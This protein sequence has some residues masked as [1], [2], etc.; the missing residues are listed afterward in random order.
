[1]SIEFPLFLKNTPFGPVSDPKIPVGIRTLAGY[2]TYGFVID[3][4]ADFAVAPGRLA[5]QIGL[6]WNALPET[7]MTGVEQGGVPARVGYLPIRVGNLE[8]SVRCLFVAIGKPLFLLGRADFLDR[9]V[10]TID[11]P[12]RR[13]ILIEVP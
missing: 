7:R 6:D 9:F 11:Q 3:T 8:F 12:Q 4:G 13:I 10:L 2:R 1:V 5:Q